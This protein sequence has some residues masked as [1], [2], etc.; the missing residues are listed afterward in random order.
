MYI[1]APLT[2]DPIPKQSLMTQMYKKILRKEKEKENTYKQTVHTTQILF[3]HRLCKPL[4]KHP[5]CHYIQ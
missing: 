5:G 3:K 1:T 2:I 4:L